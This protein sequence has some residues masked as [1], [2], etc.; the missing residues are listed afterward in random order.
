M[1]IYLWGTRVWGLRAGGVEFLTDL[2]ALLGSLVPRQVLWKPPL[3]GTVERHTQSGRLCPNLPADEAYDPAILDMRWSL[4]VDILFT[5]RLL[6]EGGRGEYGL[7]G[8]YLELQV[9]NAART[10]L[11]SGFSH[12]FDVGNSSVA[13]GFALAFLWSTTWVVSQLAMHRDEGCD[14]NGTV[15]HSPSTG[16]RGKKGGEGQTTKFV[17]L[18]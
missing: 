3:I 14:V 2:R 17:Q 8:T 13:I 12:P 7:A 1:I 16:Q 4:R 9:H 5:D 11:V 10:R 15:I 18:M 6:Y